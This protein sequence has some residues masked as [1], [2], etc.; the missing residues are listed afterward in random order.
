MCDQLKL[1]GDGKCPNCSLAAID[2]DHVK[3]YSCK[4][5][6]HAV[7]SSATPDVKL[8]NKT[9]IQQ[10][11]LPATKNN[12]V[13][14]CDRCLTQLEIRRAEGNEARIDNLEDKMTGIDQQL[15]EIMKLLKAN[16]TSR[17]EAD[18]IGVPSKENLWANKERLATVRAPEPKAKLII[19]KENDESKNAETHKV[20]ERVLI[21]NEISLAESRQS[22]EGNLVLTCESRSAR[23]ELK[24]LVLEANQEITMSS[25]KTKQQSI[26]IVGLPNDSTKEEV[27]KSII[28]QNEF[29][30]QFSLMNKIDDHITIHVIKPLRNKPT[31]FQ[32]FASVSKVLRDGLSYHKD[33]IIVGLMSCKIYDRHQV[34]RCNNCQHFGHFA[35]A[36]PTPEEPFCGKCSEN[37]RTDSCEKYERKCINCVRSENGDCNHAVTYHG[38]PAVIKQ[39]ELM[40]SKN[41]N[42]S[43]PRTLQLT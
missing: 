2:G 21:E 28:T 3:C 24:N 42:L 34:M 35:K 41:L 43:S 33:R 10:F 22:K 4:E 16:T 8:A 32:V 6:F 31:V 1:D 36:C 20:I 37:H 17:N 14:Y 39:I 9:M 27:M 29:I 25:P 5:L 19:S 38:C 40:K 26:T 11:L 13:F 12:F 18:K 30:K 7:C 23:D 15:E